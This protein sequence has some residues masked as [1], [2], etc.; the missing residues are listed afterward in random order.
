MIAKISTSNSPRG[1]LN[2]NCEKVGEGHA[3]ILCTNKIWQKEGAAAAEQLARMFEKKA[4]INKNTKN[5]F[6]HISL[7]P[8]PEDNLT[9]EQLTEIAQEYMQ[10]TGY[11]EQPCIIFKHEDI[12]RHHLHIVTTNIDA[13]GKKINDSNNFYKSKKATAEIEKKYNLHP[14]DM[15]KDLKIWM[16]ARTDPTKN[17][18]SQIRYTVKH[19]IKNY[20]FQSFNE[21]KVLL[22]LYNIGVQE[23]NGEANGAPYSGLIYFATDDNKNRLANP[24]KS[25]LLGKFAGAANLSKKYTGSIPLLKTSSEQLKD[26][27]SNA[28]KIASTE[29]DLTGILKKRNIDLILRKNDNGRIYGV[30]IID[31]NT[32]SVMNGSRLGK[33]FSANRFQELFSTPDHTQKSTGEKTVTPEQPIFSFTS[34]SVSVSLMPRFAGSGPSVPKK[35]KKKKKKNI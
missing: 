14:A 1:A 19:L 8:S 6:V 32:K 7:N 5:A 29:N 24:I 35:K 4:A 31:H 12:D 33:E 2:Y 30:T 22:S 9:D 34:E 10:K 25:S 20:H 23:L 26:T 13:Q 15:K 27:L 16:P 17:I 11:G 3:R 21:F 18:S 28:M